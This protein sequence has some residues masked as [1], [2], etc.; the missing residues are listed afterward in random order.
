MI[1]DS[2]S[3]VYSRDSEYSMENQNDQP[4]IEMFQ[5][6][7]NALPFCIFWKDKNSV[8]LGCNQALAEVAGLNSPNEYV[9]K[10]DYDLPWTKEEADFFRECDQRVIQSNQAELNIIESQKQANGNVAWL[11][12]SKI[13]LVDSNGEVIHPMVPIYF[14]TLNNGIYSKTSNW[15][16]GEPTINPEIGLS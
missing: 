12:T 10:T 7:I 14:I 5:K 9:G 13:P 15:V 2:T 16:N 3:S 11:E 8:A 1:F 6:V 4:S